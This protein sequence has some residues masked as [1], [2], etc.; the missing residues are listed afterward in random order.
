MKNYVDMNI[1][2]WLIKVNVEAFWW[3]LGGVD[4]LFHNIFLIKGFYS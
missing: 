3:M 4:L 1:S 2:G